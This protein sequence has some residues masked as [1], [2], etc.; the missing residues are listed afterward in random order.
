MKW[1]ISLFFLLLA[2]CHESTGLTGY[3]ARDVDHVDVWDPVTPDLW[4]AGEDRVVEP[5]DVPIDRAP[6]AVDDPEPP[7]TY[8]PGPYSFDG[9]GFT[10]GPATWPACIK[11]SGEEYPLE[12]ADF[13][14]F[15]CDPEVQSIA[16][17]V[18][19]LSDP[20]CPPRIAELVSRS[21]HFETYGT[22]W[23][24][25]LAWDGGVIPTNAI[26][27]SYFEDQ[28]VTF[29]WFTD[30]ADNSL[31]GYTFH[32]SPMLSGVPW[33]GVIDAKTMQVVASNP[34]DVFS[35]VQSLGTD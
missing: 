21:W 25:L 19:T 9:V 30:D 33:I 23:I 22:K 17:F 1:M 16:I 28:G 2:G 18:A 3:D 5:E 13:E 35:V 10:V 20:Y 32:N 6:E 4:D 8:P 27:Q 29:G 34:S 15:Y 11:A 12:H 14:V 24:W 31:G 26:A 7:C